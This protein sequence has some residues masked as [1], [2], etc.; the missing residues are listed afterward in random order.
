M[1]FYESKFLKGIVC[2]EAIFFDKT[3]FFGVE[4]DE[5][6]DFSRAKFEQSVEFT[7][8]SFIK[9]SYFPLSE[10]KGDVEFKNVRFHEPTEFW[11]AKFFRKALF[12]SINHH[13]EI[14]EF[15]FSPDF[16]YLEINKDA[17][18]TFKKIS[19]CFA[20]FLG[21]DLSKI[22]FQN[23]TWNRHHGR[24]CLYDEIEIHGSPTEKVEQYHEAEILYR[25]LKN[26]YEIQR[27]YKQAGDF[28]YGEMEMHRRCSRWRWIPLYWNNLYRVLSGY[29]EKPLL[30][31][32]WLLLF[33]IGLPWIVW[34]FNVEFYKA[35]KL[36]TY[37]DVLVFFLEKATFQRP[38]WLRAIDN[39]GKLLSDISIILIPGQAALF[40]LALRNRLGRRR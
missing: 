12:F 3:L 16:M 35:D 9:E 32:A 2:N 33:L 6:A 1:A 27:D 40:L 5:I 21:T 31:I 17:S 37:W 34:Y 15:E 30:A 14:D 38:D 36:A 8:V 20:N 26:R 29:G 4:I 10:F 24:N 7:D 39:W 25:A 18:I 28:H 11:G 19:L 22:E 13:G 23:V